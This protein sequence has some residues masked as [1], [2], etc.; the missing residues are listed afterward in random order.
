[1]GPGDDL[2]V[3]SGCQQ[4]LDL[5]QRVLVRAG[6]KIAVEDPVYPGVKNLFLCA[7][8]QVASYMIT[9]ADLPGVLTAWLGPLVNQ[10]SL[11]NGEG[12][13]LAKASAPTTTTA[14]AAKA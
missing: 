11:R 6:D 9:L 12:V 10:I 3:T 7:G 2:I 5:L 1:M 8:A 14:T 13:V 4:A